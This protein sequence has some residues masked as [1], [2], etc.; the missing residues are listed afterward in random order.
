MARMLGF[1]GG[2]YFVGKYPE[3]LSLIDGINNI[4]WPSVPGYAKYEC[5]TPI[6]NG[7][8]ELFG[9]NHGW[10]AQPFVD[11]SDKREV[12]WKG[13][14]SMNMPD[15]LQVFVEIELGH[16]KSNFQNLSKFELSSMLG[17]YDFFLLGVPGPKLNKEIYYPSDFVHFK[18]RANFFKLFIHAPCVIF[19]IEPPD[20]IDIPSHTGLSVDSGDFPPRMMTDWGKEFILDNNLQTTMNLV[21]DE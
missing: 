4:P 19:E 18:K 20:S 7:A 16:S 9:E 2:Q 8:I 5:H 17:S 6:L 12:N 13:D 1:F 3:L 14:L 11:T 10:K 21:N 15:G